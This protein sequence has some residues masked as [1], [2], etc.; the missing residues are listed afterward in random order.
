MVQKVFGKCE[1]KNG[2]ETDELL[3]TGT[4]GHQRVWKNAEENSNSGRRQSPSQGGK[5]LWR[6][7]VQK[8]TRKEYQR[9]V[10]KFEIVGFIAQHGFVWN[11]AREKFL[12]K[13]GELP[14]E[15]GDAERVQGY[16]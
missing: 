13:R 11:L 1:A 10:N 9:L 12:R 2:T 14:K 7:E 3:Y 6:I 16:A 4:D 8:I 5:K 15:G